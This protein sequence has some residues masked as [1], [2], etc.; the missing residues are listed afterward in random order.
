[1][2]L[3]LTRIFHPLVCLLKA[4][5]AE[6]KPAWLGCFGCLW[7]GFSNADYS[8]ASQ[9]L[10]SRNAIVIGDANAGP[11]YDRGNF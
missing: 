5:D 6:V 7:K 1:M 3:I 9:D 8:T 11:S 4:A 2:I 10:G